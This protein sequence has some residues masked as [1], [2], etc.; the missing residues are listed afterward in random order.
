MSIRRFAGFLLL[1]SS[2]PASSVLADDTS[3]S[4]RPRDLGSSSSGRQAGSNWW[5]LCRLS[6]TP[7][8]HPD[9]LPE[10]WEAN[11]IDRFVFAKLLETG[12]EPSPPAD[13]RTMIRRATYDLIGLPPTPEEV[14][15]FLR[16]CEGETGEQDRVGDGAYRRLIN[17]LLESPRYGE[18]WGRHWLD[19]VRFGESTGFERNVL[20]DNLWPFRDY[21]IRSLN[22]DKPFDQMVLEHLAGDVIGKGNTE[23][24]L[25]TAFLVCG[26]YD[27]V[28]NQDAAQ[29][30]QIR[31]NTIDE[32]IRATGET[33]FGL[34]VGCGRCHDHKFDPVSQRDYYG[35]YATFAGVF[36][37]SRV[38]ATEAERRGFEGK[39]KPLIE[40]RER[41]TKQK[42]DLDSAIFARAET[43]A[44]EYE[45]RWTRPA[46]DRRRT[47]ETFSPVEAR[48]VRLTGEATDINPYSPSGFKVDEFEVWTAGES[49]RNVALATRGGKVDARSRMPKDFA[50]AYSPILTIDGKY[51]ARWHAV[52]PSLTIVLPKPETIDRIVFSS[53]RSGAAG[54]QPIAAFVCDYR[55]EISS[56]GNQWT[57]VANSHDRKPAGASHRRKRLVDLETTTGERAKMAELDSELGKVNRELAAIPLLPTRWLGTRRQPS[58]ESHVFIGGDPQRVGELV[59]PASL[60]A[61]SK[62]TSGYQL[63]ADA[64]EGERREALAE[65]IVAPDN[66]LTPR[67]FAN[68]LWHY[69]FG[70]GIVETPNDF[71]AM[72]GRPTHPELL[73]WLARHVHASDWHP[74]PLHQLIMLSHTYRQSSDNRPE[75]ARVDHSA[76]YLW[77]FPP[78][79]LSSDEIRDAMLQVSEKLD[80]T[81]GGP[82]FRLYQYLQD[83][84]ATYVPLAKVGPETYRRSVYHQNARAARVDLMSEFD[85]PDCAFS[86]PRRATTTSP[87]QALTLMNHSFT[88]DMARALAERVV[89]DVGNNDPVDV[90]QRAYWLVFSRPA[91]EE[92]VRAAVQ[93][94]NEHGLP[95]LCRVLFNA[96][97]F[98][99][100][101]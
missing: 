35:L 76:R 67:V 37:G 45:V 4:D 21:V 32:M 63:A 82:G 2:V 20:I 50:D 100:I 3:S 70:T 15:T 49:A 91:E 71:G 10:G 90:V 85:S 69:H 80:L 78:R 74:K 18:H 14:A 1:L 19:V 84:V 88:I 33:F 36:H 81:M 40:T 41:L 23:V 13:P 38:V 62:V 96:N 95:A 26:P 73:D 65:W 93:F 72:G 43:K 5:S 64:P 22:E 68:R 58:A 86:A 83:N 27:N 56:G 92:E 44:A 53:D 24:E 55:I 99:Y 42:A 31:A 89:A 7:P 25:G 52:E 98:I 9:G 47:E 8:P 87:L 97:E 6:E 66:P 54:T 12:L 61:L 57:E 11:P 79:R 34:T 94:V 48:F 77:R 75:A 16:E 29:A 51:G 28:G 30:A 60:S 17:R 101:H 59:V 39:Q 46:A